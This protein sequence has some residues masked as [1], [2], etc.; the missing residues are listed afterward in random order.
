MRRKDAPI[1]LRTI[2]V[3][4]AKQVLYEYIKKHPGAKTSDLILKLALDPK[5]VVEALSQLSAEGRV[6]GRNITSKCKKL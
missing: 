4:E 2:S 5:V 3:E 1:K 6:E